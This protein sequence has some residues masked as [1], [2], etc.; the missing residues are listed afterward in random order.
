MIGSSS[1]QSPRTLAVWLITPD[2]RPTYGG[3]QN[4]LLEMCRHLPNSEVT[5]VT[6]SSPGDAEF[7]RTSGL[8]T[9]RVGGRGRKAFWRNAFF[10]LNVLF[11]LPKGRPDVILNGHIVTAPAAWLI[12]KRRKAPVVLYT[13]GK[14]VW[15][16]PRLARWALRH[17]AAAIAVAEFTKAKLA[18]VA[19]PP[20][21]PIH[22]VH[23]GVHPVTGTVAKPGG[24]TT[25]ITVGRLR[26]RYKGHDIVLEALPEIL[27][28]RPE[29]RWAV[30]GSGEQLGWLRAR[31][32]QLGVSASVAFLG[33]VDDE[34]KQS[35]LAGAAVFVMPTRYPRDEAAGEGFPLVYLEAAAIG[36]P[37]VAGNIGGPAEAVLDGKTGLLVDPEDP[38]AVAEAIIRLM[39]DPSLRANLG[40]AARS[41]AE[42]A[43]TWDVVA[44]DL[45]ARLASVAGEVDR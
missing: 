24:S 18:E 13:Y 3:I 26:D 40:A 8:R 28:Q 34:A 43:F 39:A 36:L 33:S 44:A 6:L 37:A 5:V 15:G 25:L 42:R 20:T 2:F 30:I 35:E 4:L 23:P 38:Q 19:Q 10:N 41:R 9:I 32:D 16:R 11:R 7:D 29:V 27:R 12:G 14:E 31:A 1:E 17:S 22:V 45:R 21:V